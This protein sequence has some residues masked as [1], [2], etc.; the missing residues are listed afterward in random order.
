MPSIENEMLEHFFAVFT[1]LILC[2]SRLDDFAE[3]CPEKESQQKIIFSP[4]FPLAPYL[5]GESEHTESGI[6]SP[7]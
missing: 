6:D 5:I 2:H 7:A 1:K 4:R 3:I